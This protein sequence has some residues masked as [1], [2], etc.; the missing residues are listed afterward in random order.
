MKQS[1][2]EL[3]NEEE[4]YYKPIRIANFYNKNYIEYERNKNTIN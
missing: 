4:N 3:E 2:T 1:K